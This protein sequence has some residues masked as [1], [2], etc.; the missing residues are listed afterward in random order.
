MTNT[1]EVPTGDVTGTL[2]GTGGVTAPSTSQSFGPIATG[3]IVCRTFTFVV[4]AACGATLTASLEVQDEGVP[5]SIVA[6]TFQVGSLAPFVSEFFDSVTAPALPSG[7][8]TVIVSG[9]VANPFRTKSFSA[10]TAPNRIGAAD[11][12]VVSDNALVSPPISVPSAGALLQFRHAYALETGWDGG[13][14][15]ISVGSGP[16]Q[17]IVTAGGVILSGGYNGTLISIGENPIRGRAAWTGSSNGYVTTLVRLPGIASGQIVRLRWRLGSDVSVSAPGWS[18]DTVSLLT[19]VCGAL[20]PTPFGKSSPGPAAPPALPASTHPVL[21][22][23]ASTSVLRYEYCVDTTNNSTCDS[24]WV[25]T[26]SS[27]SVSLA[28][29]SPGRS[30]SWQ[31]RAVNGVGTVQA[32]GGTWWSFTTAAPTNPRA[33][34]IIDSGEGLWAFSDLLAPPSPPFYLRLNDSPTALTRGDLDSNG[35]VDI[36]A[37][38][39]GNGVWA[40]MN[41][42]VW[43]HIHGFD[44]SHIDVGDL[45]ANGTDDLVVS[46]TGLGLWVRYDN[47]AWARLDTD[48]PSTLAVGNI[49][50]SAGGPEEVIS[51]FPGQG[52]R[53]YYNN[54]AW[55]PLHALDA[56]NLQLGDLDGNGVSDLIAQFPGYG[57]WIL[58]NNTTWTWLHAVDADGFVTGNLDGDAAGKDDVVVN[59]PGTG[60]WVFL[61][62]TSW[63]RLDTNN[64][65]IMA[66]GN[67]DGAGGDELRGVLPRV[68]TLRVQESHHFCGHLSCPRGRSHGDSAD[69]RALA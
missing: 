56:T 49:D 47:V 36:V 6:Y 13:V 31:V 18:I 45:N 68:G 34:L 15:E 4:S 37:N 41:N 28:G 17:D 21:A 51:T 19:Y 35:S 50:G 59:F 58:Y 7:W 32:N 26:G 16:F 8:S 43:T 66:T 53:V 54:T 42:T 24:A 10:D 69:E 27:T 65:P 55:M 44:A 38:F 57:E 12:N 14:V 48:N 62:G 40:F 39:P 3:A 11:P 46:F 9:S 20:A 22:W 60:V 63:M 30:C 64:V 23:G 25:S 33:D 5:T 2:L 1:S 61:N 67:L 29:L 52:V